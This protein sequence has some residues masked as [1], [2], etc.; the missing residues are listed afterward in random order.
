MTLD[1]DLKELVMAGKKIKD[2]QLN[3]AMV[4]GVIVDSPFKAV[5]LIWRPGLQ[6][7]ECS[8][9]CL[10]LVEKKGNATQ[11]NAPTVQH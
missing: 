9:P 8:A 2:I 7:V 5:L 11:Q 10:Q 3:V 6:Q 4:D 1:L